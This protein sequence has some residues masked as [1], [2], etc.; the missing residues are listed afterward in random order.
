MVNRRT[1]WSVRLL[2]ELRRHQSAFFLTLTYDDLNVVSDIQ[3]RENVLVKEHVQQFV[4]KLRKFEARKYG[5]KRMPIKY[6]MTA[7]Y[8]EQLGRPHYHFIMYGMQ[9]QT[10]QSLNRIWQRGNVGVGTVQPASV[11]YVTKYIITKHEDKK[12]VRPFSLMSNGI[13]KAYLKNAIMHRRSKE[14]QVVI[15]GIKYKMPRYLKEKIFN[16]KLLQ[17]EVKRLAINTTDERY[18]KEMA[19]LSK[20]HKDPFNYMVER[21]RYHHEKIK[22]RITKQVGIL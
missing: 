2:L 8:G 17:E 19:R 18:W 9:Y 10:V 4:R 12:P 13:G 16:T 14:T 6:Y 21:E 22:E 3:S 20:I 1:D 5:K 15:N 11:N 7:E